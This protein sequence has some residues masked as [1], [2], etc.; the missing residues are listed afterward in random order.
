MDKLIEM[1]K[2]EVDVAKESRKALENQYKSMDN[3]WDIVE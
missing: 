3:I 1:E 2:A